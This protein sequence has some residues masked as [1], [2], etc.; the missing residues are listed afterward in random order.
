M[1]GLDEQFA[2]RER[3]VEWLQER[4]GDAAT[5][6]AAWGTG[7]ASLEALAAGALRAEDLASERA[8][9]DLAEFNRL[10]IAEYVRVPSEEC[11]RVDPEHMNLGVRYAW[12]AHDDLLAGADVFDVFSINGYQSGPDAAVIKKCSRAA[13]APVLIGEFHTGALDRGLP[14]GGLRMV[15]SQEERADSYRYYVEQGAAI[16]ELVGAHYFLWNDQHVVGRFDGE[17]W[18]IGLVD[19]CQKPYAGLIA[20]AQKSHARIYPVAS[21]RT[22]PFDNLPAAV[23][24][25]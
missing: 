1:L 12:I 15:R 5:L 11:R 18:Q 8:Q 6:N 20:A 21:G 10:M 2:S 7:L 13:D 9:A 24:V 4:Y 16:P 17:N 25:R 19:I 23:D 3:L 14:W 22:E